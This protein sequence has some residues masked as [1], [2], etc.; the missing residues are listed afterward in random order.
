MRKNLFLKT[1]PTTSS[2]LGIFFVFIEIL[3][4]TVVYLS[5]KLLLNN[6]PFPVFGFFWFF[7]GLFW[8][9]L[10][11]LFNPHIRQSL[12]DIFR[13]PIF[14]F[15]VGFLDAIAT[16]MWFK[17]IEFSPNPSI[18]SFMTNVSPI[19]ALILG[20]IFHKER[21]KPLEIAG[22][23]ITFTGLIM[24]SFQK[25]MTVQDFML[26]NAGII[27][28]SSL[29]SQTGKTILKFRVSSFH[30]VVF[31]VNRLFFLLSFVIIFLLLEPENYNLAISIKQIFW[32]FLFS[33]FGPFLST[34]VGYKALSLL[35]MSTYSFLSSIKSLF[36]LLASYIFLHNLPFLHQIIGGILSIIGF[37][38]ISMKN[39]SNQFT[40]NGS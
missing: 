36:I 14:M 16:V 34:I 21:F 4:L 39:K 31:A 7:S 29:I 9:V 13:F 38:F 2:H 30:P 24:I 20:Y 22:M 18:V 17:A 3:S 8:N 5:T 27:L 11:V 28:I 1:E 26:K 10:L 40:K 37:L 23:L 6:L 33:F 35:K 32:I 15:M 19:Y 12:K 25:N